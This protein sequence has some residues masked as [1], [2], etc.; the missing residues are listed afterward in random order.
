MSHTADIWVVFVTTDTVESARALAQAVVREGCAACVNIVPGVTSIYVWEGA[1]REDAECL[2][3]I[4]TT[5]A[6]YPAL[7]ACIRTHHTYDTPEI[8]AIAAGAVFPAYA[9]WVRQSCEPKASG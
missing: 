4:K 7:E 5:A 6:R 2:L 8:L 3:V 1:E 9:A